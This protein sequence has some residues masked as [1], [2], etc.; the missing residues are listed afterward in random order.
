MMYISFE[1]ANTVVT[2]LYSIHIFPY[3]YDDFFQN[4]TF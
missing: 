1:Y 4:Q 3:R 2:T